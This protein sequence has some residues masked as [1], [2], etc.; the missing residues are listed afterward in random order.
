MNQWD[1]W[2]IV[3]Y[4]KISN[5]PINAWNTN[6]NGPPTLVLQF[7][8]QN[9]WTRYYLTPFHHFVLVKNH[10]ILQ[11]SWPST[12]RLENWSKLSSLISFPVYDRNQ[13]DKTQSDTVLL[14]EKKVIKYYKVLSH[15]WN[16]WKSN[17]NGTP[18]PVLYINTQI[19]GTKKFLMPF[20]QSKKIGKK[21]VF[22]MQALAIL[23]KI[24][25]NEFF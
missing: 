13:W 11:I 9:S 14:L 4:F 23:D 1:L 16:T 24:N 12:K 8:I 17:Q 21:T 15:P 6:L 25:L 2:K 20:W 3:K 10:E 18:I 22:S 5:H 19:C 7:K